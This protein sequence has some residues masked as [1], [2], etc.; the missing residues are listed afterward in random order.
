MEKII[1]C[2]Q[3]G[4]ELGWL[5]DPSAKSVTV[6]HQ[7]QLPKVHLVNEGNNEPLAV[8]SGLETWQISAGDIFNWLKV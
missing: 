7:N 4:T 3:Q 8:I 5:I 6:F 1:F 2:L